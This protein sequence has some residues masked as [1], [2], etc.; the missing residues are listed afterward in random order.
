MKKRHIALT[1]AVVLGGAWLGGSWYSGKLLAEQYPQLVE[2]VNS[3]FAQVSLTS[4]YKLEYKTTNYNKHLFTTT[5]ENQLVVTNTQDN[6]NYTLPF[7]ILVE[8]GPLPLSRLLT[9]R[10][11]PVMASGNI[12]LLNDPSISPIFDASDSK[13]PLKGDFSVGYDQRVAQTLDFAA[14]HYRSEDGSHEFTSS[15]FKFISD[16]DL[17]GIGKVETEIDNL[18]I[19][20]NAN[21]GLDGDAMPFKLALKNVVVKSD[22]QP[23]EYK[24]IGVGTQHIKLDALELFDSNQADAK[25]YFSLHNLDA[26]GDIALDND[27]VNIRSKLQA[28]K[29]LLSGQDLGKLFYDIAFN[30]LDAKAL[31]ELMSTIRNAENMDDARLEHALQSAGMAFFQHQP[32]LK[33]QPFSLTN[34]AGENKLTADIAFAQTDWQKALMKG[35]VLSLFERFAVNADVNKPALTETL[36]TLAM[37]DDDVDAQTAQAQAQ[38]DVDEMLQSAVAENILHQQSD[39]HYTLELKLDNGELKLNGQVIPEKDI[40]NMILM[41]I[42][43]ASFY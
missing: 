33:L 36:K 31:D 20:S 11:L 12:E 22:Y 7:K 21:D 2:R 14:M 5:I 38:A 25:T 9:L 26:N 13:T 18:A 28:D 42:L 10:W 23:S 19:T 4:P 43:G 41:G 8:H 35:K 32:E 39:D 1:L 27:S 34:S 6:K 17:N 15:P 29:M 30:H 24:N 16:T 40:A 3:E 37:G